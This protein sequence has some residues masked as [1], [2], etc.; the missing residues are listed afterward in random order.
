ME[1]R[2]TYAKNLTLISLSSLPCDNKIF[3]T[4]LE[5]CAARGINLDMVSQTARKGGTLN[6]SVTLSDDDLAD[7]LTVLGELRAKNI[8]I[9][10]EILPSSCKINYYDEAMVNTPGVAAKVFTLLSQADVEVMLVT[11]SDYDI[12][13]LIPAHCLDDA[14]EAMG[15]GTGLTP[16]EV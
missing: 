9:K 12:S 6:M 10:P 8:K 3:A 11:T 14:L 1:A 5:A 13:V 16:V 2:L 15:N 7:I 4:V